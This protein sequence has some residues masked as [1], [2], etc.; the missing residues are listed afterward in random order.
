[1]LFLCPEHVPFR[2]TSS[3]FQP[4]PSLSQGKVI[5]EGRDCHLFH[6]QL[7]LQGRMWMYFMCI[8]LMDAWEDGVQVQWASSAEGSVGL[9]HLQPSLLPTDSAWAEPTVPSSGSMERSLSGKGT[10]AGCHGRKSRGGL[11]R[12][13][14]VGP[15]RK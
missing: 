15:P 8:F 5:R 9:T 13:T 12:G 6:S 1:M 7:G 2:S 10:H 3:L 14:K 4:K 11:I